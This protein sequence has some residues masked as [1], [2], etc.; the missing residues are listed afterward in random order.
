MELRQLRYFEAVARECN[1]T[2]AA[3]R[4]GIAQ[5]P[6][7]RQ[8][9][10][11]E[12]EFGI[13][14]FDRESRPIRLTEAGRLCYEQVTQILSSL[15][16]LRHGMA[17]FRSAAQPRFVIGVVGSIM[18]GAM[19]RIIRNFRAH[20]PKLDVELVE[21]TT[22]EQVDALK[23]GRCDSG[24]GRV[25]IDDP[26]VRRE[27]LYE[28]ALVAALP[29]SDPLAL[30]QSPLSIAS[31]TSKV[32]IIYPSQPR[33]SYADQVLTLFRDYGA[34][35]TR[36]VEVR[37]VQ[38][39]MGLVAAQSG[40][41]IVPAS[42][43]YLQSEDIVYRPLLEAEATSPIILSQRIND[44]SEEARRFREIARQVLSG[45]KIAGDARHPLQ[46]SVIDLSDS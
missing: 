41:A 5:P 22:L 18:H 38:T 23:S 37:E 45:H 4:V 30:E 14:L 15:E 35:P 6:L 44:T 3:K 33:P 29:A 17:R 42:M 19:P 9:K 8:I 13:A 2:R 26:A 39:A 1:F 34:R 46:R 16:Q 25:R 43:Q 36:V 40:V 32:L 11:L 24:L 28:E 20:D 7:S 12:D 27:I 31:L 10:A 21:L